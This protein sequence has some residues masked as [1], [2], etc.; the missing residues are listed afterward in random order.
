[1]RPG[2][3]RVAAHRAIVW[4]AIY[5]SANLWPTGIE[6]DSP[7]VTRFSASEPFVTHA[8]R[9][10]SRELI[11]ES[12]EVLVSWVDYGLASRSFDW[13]R[14]LSRAKLYEVLLGYELSDARLHVGHVPFANKIDNGVEPNIAKTSVRPLFSYSFLH[15][16]PYCRFRLSQDSFAYPHRYSPFRTWQ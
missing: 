10:K 16:P 13:V 1:M 9:R 15:E 7:G 12:T 8:S 4:G 3:G 5:K 6:P 14:F 2:R 11:S